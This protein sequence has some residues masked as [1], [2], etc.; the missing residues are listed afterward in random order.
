MR[1]QIFKH[2][3]NSLLQPQTGAPRFFKAALILMKPFMRCDVQVEKDVAALCISS[4][5][6][7][8]RAGDW[9]AS[10]GA[11][12]LGRFVDASKGAKALLQGAGVQ[13]ALQELQGAAAAAAAGKGGEAA[14]AR[15]VLR[16]VDRL[17]ARGER[18]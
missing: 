13:Q 4:A 9:R 6:T 15:L 2:F 5:L 7:S 11:V 8:A 1:K 12:R 18:R 3:P 10:L 17:V 16:Q 14:P